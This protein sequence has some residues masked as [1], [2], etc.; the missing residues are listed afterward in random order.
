[1]TLAPKCSVRRSRRRLRAKDNLWGV[2]LLIAA[3][4]AIAACAAV[5][6]GP[7]V[8]ALAGSGKTL[9]QFQMDDWTCRESAAREI[10]RSKS[11]EVPAQ[12]R[13]D[14]AYMQC[15]Y[16][17]GH[18]IPAVGERPSDTSSSGAVPPGTPTAAP[19][20]WP[21]TRAQVDCERS[22][23]VWRAALNFCEFPAPDVP[24]RRWR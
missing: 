13:Y 8:M 15:M 19:A 5:P 11:G 21:P 6:T 14:M 23:G 3:C 24:I 17:K 16:A 4:V 7:S 22:G 1:M 12:G 2:M 10:E 20:V 9:E 18:R